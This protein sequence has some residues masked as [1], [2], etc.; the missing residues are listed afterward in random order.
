MELISIRRAAVLL[1]IQL[2]RSNPYRKAKDRE[3]TDLLVK[4]FGFLKF[5]KTYEEYNNAQNGAT[6]ADGVFD[7]VQVTELKIFP[8]GILIDTGESTDIAERLFSEELVAI[9]QK[10]GLDLS[11]EMV[12]ERAYISQLVSFSEIDLLALSAPVTT[13]IENWFRQKPVGVGSVGVYTNGNLE[14]APPV[15]IERVAGQPLEAMQFWSQTPLRT[16]LHIEFLKAWE[17]A[18]KG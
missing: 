7:G 1:Y 8:N 6:F 11:K 15:R 14:I 2:E 12:S 4:R 13:L 10:V 18:L 9:W 16:P 17:T 5:P 3:I